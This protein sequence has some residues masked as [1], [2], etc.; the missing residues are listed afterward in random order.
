M[1]IRRIYVEG[2]KSI[3]ALALELGQVNVFI[4]RNGAGKSTLLEACAWGKAQ[5]ETDKNDGLHPLPPLTVFSPV[6]RDLCRPFD[7]GP[8]GTLDEYGE[9]LLSWLR[10]L[11]REEPAAWAAIVRAV[12]D[13]ESLSSLDFNLESGRLQVRTI[14][15]GG[16]HVLFYLFIVISTRMPRLFAVENLHA[17]LS[18]SL[19]RGLTRIMVEGIIAGDKQALLMTHNPFVLDGMDLQDERQRLFVV[20]RDSEQNIVVRR[21]QPAIR[22][23]ELP[24]R[25]SDAFERTLLGE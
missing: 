7:F 13:I 4:G 18:P 20:S 15:E 19:S 5:V 14:G 1:F 16:L 12:R 22:G 25:L 23:A 6:Y 3:R 9:G 11:P 10:G 2:Y 17:P 8:R 24:M 21:V